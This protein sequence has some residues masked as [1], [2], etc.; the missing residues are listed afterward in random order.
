[1]LTEKLFKENVVL[2]STN[3][4]FQL[5][6][7]YIKLVYTAIKDK[8]FDQYFQKQIDKIIF[9]QTLENWNSKFG[10]KGY[11]AVADCIKMFCVERMK[12]ACE[13][14]VEFNITV[15][16]KLETYQEAIA[17]EQKL[18]DFNNNIKKIK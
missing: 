17:R 12:V 4:N 14:F 2:L 1:M 6:A 8:T 5:T 15:S 11:P 9:N 10:F 3:F 16:S 13:P 18:L 7:G